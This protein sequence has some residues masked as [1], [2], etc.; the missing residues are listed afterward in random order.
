[1]RAWA[2]ALRM[3]IRTSSSSAQNAMRNNNAVARPRGCVYSFTG[4]GMG[5]LHREVWRLVGNHLT[6]TKQIG[7]LLPFSS[8]TGL[9]A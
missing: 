7:T 4:P 3:R 9:K 5:S 1:M 8:S 2:S 6:L